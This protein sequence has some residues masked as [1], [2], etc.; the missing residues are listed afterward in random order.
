MPED[1]LPGLVHDVQDALDRAHAA[2]LAMDGA[3]L[4]RSLHTAA[5]LLDNAVAQVE[6][7]TG[8]A[9]GPT[10]LHDARAKIGA[11]LQDLDEGKLA[12]MEPLIE[13]VRVYLKGH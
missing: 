8:E 13:A 11:A 9:A 4:R 1:P 10:G 6:G 7:S 2:A 5:E 12:E 3:A